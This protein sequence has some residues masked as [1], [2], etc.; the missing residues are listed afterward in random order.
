MRDPE[1]VARAQ[2]AAARLELAWEHWRGLQG[3]ANT[4]AQPV[5]G[6]VGY[7]LREPWG[8]PRAVI[9]F[10]ADEAEKLADFLEHD[11]SAGY[12]P[13]QLLPPQQLAAHPSH[14][15]PAQPASGP[16]PS[17]TPKPSFTPVP[18]PTPQPAVA[19]EVPAQL[20]VA[21]A[22]VPRP[23]AAQPVT[24]QPVT[25]QALSAEALSAE[26]GSQASPAEQ[27]P[28]AEQPDAGQAPA[29]EPNAE[30]A[31]HADQEP[32]A[33]QEADAAPLA[34]PDVGQTPSA[35]L[36]ADETPSVGSTAPA[37]PPANPKAGRRRFA[38]P[39][40]GRRRFAEPVR[41][42]ASSTGPAGGGPEPSAEPEAPLPTA[43]R[44][45]AQRHLPGPNQP[46][47]QVVAEQTGD[48]PEDTAAVGN[49]D[50]TSADLEAKR[51]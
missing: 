9:G 30:A 51:F 27:R 16:Q 46:S 39:K 26:A 49:D 4:P 44:Q 12:P 29:A 1:Q 32:S 3:L 36:K 15:F 37:V 14:P 13:S 6:Y 10:S 21:P 42:Q 35:E 50:P 34:E 19:H 20:A 18:A 43:Q 38:Q 23:P 8:Q 11:G 24:A 2:R 33:G 17:F 48:S 47:L 22:S 5:V 45:S 25:A 31:P 40:A 7:A 41:R 28:D